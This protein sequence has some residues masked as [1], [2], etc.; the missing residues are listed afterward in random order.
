MVKKKTT[1][2]RK[3][4]LF[5]LHFKNNIT[6]ITESWKLPESCFFK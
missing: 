3:F 6:F 2:K 1:T 5:A 4:P